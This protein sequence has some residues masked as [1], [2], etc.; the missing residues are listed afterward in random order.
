MARARTEKMP[1]AGAVPAPV[2][3]TGEQTTAR[4]HLSRSMLDAF[5]TNK[6]TTV[7]PN[8][9]AAHEVAALIEQRTALLDAGADH[10]TL[11]GVPVGAPVE[12][13]HA[14]Y[15]E[16]SR[17]LR[18][19]RLEELGVPDEGFQAQRLLAQIGIAFTVLTDRYRRSEYLA[20]LQSAQR[21]AGAGA[22]PEVHRPG[23]SRPPVIRIAP[24]RTRAV[25]SIQ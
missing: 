17:N 18:P 16:L 21:Q 8:A 15:V 9:L 11:L 22:R 24:P 3:P 23:V 4:A 1:P 20:S 10:F 19:K 5:R 12:D 13:V 14:A 6:T 2:D 7:R 25:S